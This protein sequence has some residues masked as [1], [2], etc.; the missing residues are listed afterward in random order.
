MMRE[1]SEARTGESCLLDGQDAAGAAEAL[2]PVAAVDM[3]D[4][5]FP[6][7]VAAGVD[8][9][10]IPRVDA[11]M[12]EG[13]FQCVEKYQITRFQIGLDHLLTL[14][15]HLTGRPWQIDVLGFLVD[16]F[17]ESAAIHALFRILAPEP[18]GCSEH[19]QGLEQGF[20]LF[21]EAIRDG[22]SGKGRMG[23]AKAGQ[24]K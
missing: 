14:P 9:F 3:G 23:E 12:G 17:H 4:G 5:D 24:K 20:D 18:V 8:E 7:P 19:A 16:G 1:C 10:P 15:A 13:S 22:V 2:G 11:D 6:C 21:G